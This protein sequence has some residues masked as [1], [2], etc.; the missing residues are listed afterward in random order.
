MDLGPG[1]EAGGRVGQAQGP[2]GPARGRVG[3]TQGPVAARL[4]R[5]LSANWLRPVNGNLA[6][7]LAFGAPSFR[8]T[9]QSQ[10]NAW[11]GVPR[12]TNGVESDDAQ[13]GDA[14]DATNGALKNGAAKYGQASVSAQNASSSLPSKATAKQQSSPAIQGTVQKQAGS[15]T[16]R[17]A[18]QVGQN[19]DARATSTENIDVTAIERPG[20]TSH[21]RGN[22]AIQKTGEGK[23]AQATTTDA[24]TIVP[25]I[26]APL[27]LPILKPAQS[28]AATSVPESDLAPAGWRSTQSSESARWSGAAK[29][30]SATTSA[31]ASDA[32]GVSIATGP[33]TQTVPAGQ[34]TNLHNGAQSV[35]I[36]GTV[37]SSVD[38]GDAPS[39]SPPVIAQVSAEARHEPWNGQASATGNG[40]SGQ[41]AATSTPDK[42]TDPASSGSAATTLAAVPDAVQASADAMQSSSTPVADRA[43]LRSVHRNA[44]GETALAATQVAAAQPGIVDASAS[45]GLRNP[46]APGIAAAS[47]HSVMAPAT[48]GASAQDTFSALDAGTSSGTPSWIHAGSQHAEAGFR[49]PALGWVGV[50]ADLDAGGIHATLMPSSAEAAQ[51]LNGHL[52][53]LSSHLVEQQS[54]VASLT[55]ASPN[56][57]RSE[58]AMGQHMQQ[59]AEGNPQ[60]TASGESPTTSQEKAPPVTRTSVLSAPAQAGIRDSLAHPELRGTHISVMA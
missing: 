27:Q 22:S 32:S 13:E 14:I 9:W 7:N 47:D 45:S 50:R 3:Q 54:P 23:T 43:V 10:V 15:Q 53:G 37:V 30:A 28:V 5:E 56:E 44:A 51:A 19:T 58:N 20:K 24:Q 48:L 38:E 34:A 40:L 16:S 35:A 25:I 36:H 42:I 8:S 18:W 11:R 2:G 1:M 41:P 46:A 39:A 31:V 52:A 57:S 12:A 4:G 55:M 17:S 21:D 26:E 60:Q 59:G 29:I 49:D 33:R 6:T